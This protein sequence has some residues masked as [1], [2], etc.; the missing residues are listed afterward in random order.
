M[1]PELTVATSSLWT[2]SDRELDNSDRFATSGALPP[3]SGRVG[4]RIVTSSA[5]TNFSIL[6][7][8]M[9]PSALK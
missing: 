6:C 4:E 7:V 1:S 8:A 3:Q 5:S 9:V 2:Q